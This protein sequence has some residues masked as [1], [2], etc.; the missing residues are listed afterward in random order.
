MS[1]RTM[2]VVEEDNNVTVL[3]MVKA[4][5]IVSVRLSSIDNRLLDYRL[6]TEICL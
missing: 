1:Q 5:G 6:S 2:W 3:T 4:N